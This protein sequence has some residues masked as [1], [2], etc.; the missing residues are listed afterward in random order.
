MTLEEYASE[1]A[2]LTQSKLF[3]ADVM[4]RVDVIHHRCM[5]EVPGVTREALLEAFRGCGPP[6]TEVTVRIKDRLICPS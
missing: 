2:A 5:A 4:A 3:L 1:L 6:H